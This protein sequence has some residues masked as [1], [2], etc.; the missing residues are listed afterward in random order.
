[1]NITTRHE[2][3]SAAH[4]IARLENLAS[5]NA[6]CTD[7]AMEKLAAADMRTALESAPLVVLIDACR[8]AADVNDTQAEAVLNEEIARRNVAVELNADARFFYDNAGYSHNPN[9]ETAEQGHVR[10]ALSLAAAEGIARN[11]GVSFEWSVDEGT[12]SSEFSN[13]RPWYDLYVCIAYDAAG[14]V[15][16]SLGGIDFGRDKGPRESDYRRVVEAEL[17]AEYVDQTLNSLEG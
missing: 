1:M 8:V 13:K 7:A 11:A 14:N 5:R 17:A 2:A 15:C 16:G 3:Y 6:D 9:T 10:S 4:Q 12:D